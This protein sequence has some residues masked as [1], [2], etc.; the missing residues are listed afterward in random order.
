VVREKAEKKLAKALKKVVE[1]MIKENE[2]IRQ[3]AIYQVVTGRVRDVYAVV[4]ILLTDDEDLAIHHAMS[5]EE[6]GRLLKKVL[7]VPDYIS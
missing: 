3:K 5:A 6:Y 7:E 4:A 2:P 1:I